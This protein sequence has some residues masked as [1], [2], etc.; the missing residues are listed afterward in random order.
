[1]KTSFPNIAQYRLRILFRGAFLLLAVATI[2]MALYV[3]Q[4]EKQL[5]YKNYQAS[6]RKTGDQVLATLRH[7]AGQLALLNPRTENGGAAAL[8]PILLPFPSLDFDDQ[9]KVRQAITMSGCLVQ[10]GD[11]GA[12]CVAIGNN[13]WAGGFIYV[14]G[15]FVSGEL[16]PH[17][18]GEQDIGDAHRVRVTVTLRGQTYRWIAPFEKNGDPN[19]VQTR[20]AHGRLTGFLDDDSGRVG[21]R[22]VKDF[23]GWI[24]QNTLCS[25]PG[26]D[27]GAADC[28]RS[29]FFSLRLP[30]GVLQDELFQKKNPVWPPADLDNIKVRIEVLPPDDGSPLFDSQSAVAARA[31]AVG[32]LAS[33][34]LP[35]ESLR[36]KKRGTA[37][38]AD[39]VSL[40]GAEDHPDDA[41]RLLSRLVRRL[42]VDEVGAPNESRE[43]V[44]TSAGIYDVTL[45][46]DERSVNR[47]LG[48]VAA[49][50][51]W[52]VGA[53]LLALFVAWLIIEIGIIRR[54]TMLTRRAA[55]VS[56]IVKG[57]GG[58]DQFDL[59]DLR[60][61]D[62]LGV[63]ASCLHDL[64]RRVKEDVEREEIRAEQEKEMWHAVGHEIMSP[65]QSL[66]ALHGTADSQS[67]RYINRMQQAVRVLYGSAS[68]SEAFQST[69]LQVTAIDI[70]AF[71][72]NV[73][74]NAPLV[75]IA[76][77]R[78]SGEREGVMVR[79]DDY[80]LEDVVTHVL[81]NADRCR[82]PGSMISID[83]KTTETAATIAIHNHGSNI[84]EELI[85]KIFEYGV[86]DQLEAGANGS[87]GQGLF[88]AK[89]YMAKMG[90]TITALNVAD[91]VVFSLGL[92]RV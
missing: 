53:M 87:R 82:Q 46:G 59:T 19:A 66:M 92:Q 63:L 42:P 6:F 32:D 64:L 83:L 68:P 38:G 88:V 39:L 23:R 15:S 80:S 48:V 71:L 90:G 47:S 29:S 9:N 84:A 45:I 4:Q 20:G 51:L 35:G 8:H 57:S 43:S 3:L 58:L 14:A 31:F 70:G 89:T 73:A 86:S 75:G 78:F 49:R 62:E 1:M 33:L 27:D 52:F 85:D 37:D 28:P 13:P 50:V 55:K 11:D 76:D 5:S 17:Q 74:D 21:S 81:R 91:G 44:V 7:P 30:V 65:L 79:A 56:K 77:V 24:W 18:R 54:I 34:L 25:K 41:S 72:G 60:G 16:M 12:L 40:I 2:A 10:Y 22:P 26:Q 61:A 67:S 36:I 69:V